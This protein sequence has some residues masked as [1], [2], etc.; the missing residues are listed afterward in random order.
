MSWTL[1]KYLLR[2]II[3]PFALALALLTLM[4]FAGGLLRL[5]EFLAT[6]GVSPADVALL[7]LYRLPYVLVFTI[8]MALLLAVLVAY[9]RLA[10]DSEL[11]ALRAAGLSLAQTLPAPLVASFLAFALTLGLSVYA[12]PLGSRGYKQLLYDVARQRVDLAFEEQGFSD[13]FGDLV[14]Y[15]NS[16]PAPGR[17]G[18]IFIYDERDPELPNSVLAERGEILSDPERAAVLLRLRRGT[19]FRVSPDHQVAE[20]IRFQRY[21]LGLDLERLVGP[22]S[23]LEKGASDMGLGE[24]SRAIG[25]TPEPERRHRLQMEL[26]RRFAL[27]AACLALGLVAVPLGARS[28]LERGWGIAFGLGVFLLYYLLLTATWSAS[29]AGTLPYWSVWLP[30]LAVGGL[31]LLLVLAADGRLRGRGPR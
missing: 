22:Y 4:L 8:P 16:I 17:L 31:A 29:D 30:N 1:Y 18:D 5:V 25:A 15:V 23:R 21:D 26:Q 13:A 6:R 11:V 28:R 3:T 10:N 24:L 7:L 20:A 9:L 27:P 12:K 19:I 14:V 2:E